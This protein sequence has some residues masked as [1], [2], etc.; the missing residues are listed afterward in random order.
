MAVTL[1][2]VVRAYLADTEW[3]KQMKERAAQHDASIPIMQSITQQFISQEINLQEFT[4]KL[5]KALSTHAPWGARN[6]SFITE[7]H[8]LCKYHDEK[9]PIAE[10][11]LR[12]ILTGLEA[13]NLGARIELFYD[14]LLHERERL[15]LQGKTSGMTAAAGKSAFIIS[16][17]AFWLDSIHQPII[18]H[19][20]VRKGL[21]LSLQA[22]ILPNSFAL[23]I[24]LNIVEVTS[25]ADHLACLNA[26]EYLT[27]RTPQLIS[28]AYWTEYF[29]YWLVDHFQ[30]LSE[31][32]IT[33]IK[34][35]DEA[36]LLA[37]TASSGPVIKET[38]PTYALTAPDT[39]RTDSISLI[40]NEPLHPTP[41]PLLAE[42]I[43]EVQRSILIDEATVRRIYHA[44]LAGHSILTGPPGTGKT[45]LARIIPEILWR[46]ETRGAYTT[47]LVTATGEWS[48]RTLIGGIT[49][50]SKDGA[51]SYGIQYGYLTTTILKNWS[52]DSHKPEEWNTLRRTTIAAPSGIERGMQQ[53]FRGQWLVIDEFNRAPI[54]VA[55]GDALTALSGGDNEALRVP[56][57]DGSAELPI[58]RDFRIIGTLN[59]FDRTFLNQISEALKRR[60]AFI[61]ILPPTRAQRLEEQG[62]VLYKALK[63]ITHL[64]DTINMDE[65]E[66]LTWQG[67]I[68]SADISGFYTILWEDEQHPF[69]EAFELAWRIFEVIRI[70][71]QL[72][73]AQAISLVRHMLIAGIMQAYTT[74]QQW[75]EEAL[76]QALCDTLADQLQ[77]LLPDEIETLLLYLTRDHASFSEAYTSLLGRLS[78]DRIYGQLLA[79]G[80][81]TDDSGQALLSASEIERIAA[82][83]TPLVP[84]TLLADLFH[85]GQP[86][87]SLPQFTRRLH[88]FKAERGL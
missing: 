39:M 20:S 49:P 4:T 15:R 58:P 8:K 65:E 29:F 48:V 3:Q 71:R 30:L 74:R 64:S 7:L 73:T 1:D 77:V 69:R 24:N 81:V 23:R 33:L 38:P 57:K 5:G 43:H 59:S 53:T 21:C 47:R 40:P 11:R 61:E 75:I 67:G 12:A 52:F 79:L 35:T 56:I 10:T 28:S 45:E 17:F 14:F 27:S 44:L 88:T 55:L 36:G 16:L 85:A 84:A 51:I 31:P 42:L 66:T 62:I 63:K 80:S 32:P 46:S 68:I 60:F 70:Y 26:I 50:Q 13:N 83:D 76:D 37:E 25:E 18:Y 19:E 78:R 22:G 2:E 6:F 82:Q 86:R 41:E 87:Y 54:D 9:E 34:E 72:G